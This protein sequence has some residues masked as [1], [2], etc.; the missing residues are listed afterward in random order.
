MAPVQKS[1]RIEWIDIAKALG[2]TLVVFG[3]VIRGLMQSGLL[4]NPVWHKI[5]FAIYTF[6]MPLFFFLSG[7][8]VMGSRGK[9]GFFARRARA[10][11]IP[12]FVFSLLQGGVQLA[13]AGKTNGAMSVGELLRIPIDPIA[14]FWFL[15]VL[16]IY[17][18]LVS[19]WKPGWPMLALGCVTMAA[20]HLVKDDH[21]FLFQ[22]LYFLPFYVAGCLFTP[23]R[24]SLPAGLGAVAVYA[25]WVLGALAL[26]VSDRAFYA[27]VMLPATIAGIVA[28]IWISQRMEGISRVFTWIGENVIAIY[29]MH[30][31]A[32]SGV[33]I[34]L[35]MAGIDAPAIQIVMGM[36]GGMGLPLLALVV[37]QRI[38]MA[39]W[40]GLP[41]GA[42]R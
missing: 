32:A 41:A 21:Y 25:A 10:I 31:L 26:G 6:H 23:G 17:V 30:I 37:L 27:P 4:E 39:G 36:L 29:V 18:A 8:N 22:I 3:H 24:L 7:L 16:F 2:I 14:P 13:L 20:S 15:Y 1:A 9:G 38:G 11:V 5:D 12:Y 35:K 42:R 34:I 28:T 33:R 19:V 40:V